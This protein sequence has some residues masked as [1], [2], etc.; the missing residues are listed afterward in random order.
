MV[1]FLWRLFFDYFKINNH[2]MEIFLFL[3]SQKRGENEN[4]FPFLFISQFFFFIHLFISFSSYSNKYFYL[5]LA[6]FF[7][8]YEKLPTIENRMSMKKFSFLFSLI[9]IKSEKFYLCYQKAIQ[10]FSKKL[11][12]RKMCSLLIQSLH[13]VP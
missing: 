9:E 10:T 1:M 2:P 11:R 8:H 13:H 6:L 4:V 7:R 5:K 12:S 3:K